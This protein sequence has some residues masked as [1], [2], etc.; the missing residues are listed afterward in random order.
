MSGSGKLTRR[1]FLGAGLAGATAFSLQGEARPRGRTRGKKERPNIILILTDQQHFETISALGAGGLETPGMDAIC[2]RGLVFNLSHSAYPLCSPDRSSLLTGRMPSE[3]GV[4]KN[5]VPI[6]PSIPNAGQWLREKGGYETIYMGKWHLPRPFSP[7]IPGFRV[8]VP[9]IW[10]QGN[11]GDTSVSMGVKAYL[12]SRKGKR[13]FF[14]VASFLQPHDIC[15]WLRINQDDPGGL[16]YPWLEKELPPLPSNFRF[17][18]PEP[19]ALVSM[20]EGNEPGSRKGNWSELHWRYYLYCYYRHVEMVDAEV[21]RILEALGETGR[22]NDTLVIFTSDHGEGLARHRM[23]RKSFLY[24]EAVRVPLVISPPGGRERGV[25]REHLVSAVDVFPTICDYAGV[26]P[27][28]SMRGLSLRPVLEGKNPAWHDFV[29]AELSTGESFARMVRTRDY[30]YIE[31]RGDP[32]KLLFHC[33]KDPWET[34]NL[35]SDRSYSDVLE[36][37]RRLLARWEREL[38]PAPGLPTRYHW[39][40]EV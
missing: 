40:K 16:R 3:T 11:L 23:V 37:I 19:R 24:D 27:P 18:F 5:G 32:V 1:N 12:E 8:V 20:R 9:G 17:Q 28:P 2:S 39:L 4:F 6:H 14:L 15:Q 25:D 31:Y 13:P 7:R 26:S 21:G 33:G 36:E 35:A 10:G 29:I 34:R 30:K 38:V 22:L